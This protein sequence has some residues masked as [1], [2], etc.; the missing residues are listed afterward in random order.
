MGSGMRSIQSDGCASVARYRRE[1]TARTLIIAGATGDL[2]RRLLLPGLDTVLAAAEKHGRDLEIELVGVGRSADAREEWAQIVREALGDGPLR[3]RVIASTRYEV[4]DVGSRDDLLSLLASAQHEPVLYFALPPA[5]SETAVASLRGAV[6][7]EGTRFVLEK[8]FGRDRETAAA[9]NA[10]LTDLLPESHV[11]RVDHFLGKSTVVNLLGLRF[12]NRVFDA[13]WCAEHIERIDI[14][15]DETLSLEGRAD[16]YDETGALVD[17]I[18]SHLLLVHALVT[19]DAPASI[20]AHD[21]HDAM[22]TALART[23]LLDRNAQT[24]SR[25]ARYTAGTVDGTTVP[26]YAGEE[27]VDSQRGT[28]TL[29]EIMLEVDSPR[30]KGVPIVLRSG[31]AIGA[32]ATEIRATLRPPAHRPNGLSGDQPTAAIRISLSPEHLAI[33][34]DINGEGDPF[35]LERVQV[36]TTFGSGELDAYGEVIDGI[37]GGDETLSVRGDVAEECWRIIDEVLAAW[38]EGSVPLEEYPAGSDGPA[39]WTQTLDARS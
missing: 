6:L 13:L 31:K 37:L 32:P 33:D 25:R 30:W 23:H 18:Q 39:A 34:L 14:V 8:P 16:Y 15:Y 27:G 29:A 38:R 9:L 4:A 12:A 22:A 10:R 19:M 35:D 36:S 1:M 17:M 24:A 28:E 7:P 26:D 20:A 5:I 2:T 11:H 3:K 21:L